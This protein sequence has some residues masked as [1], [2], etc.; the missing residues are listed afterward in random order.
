MFYPYGYSHALLPD[1]SLATYQYYK[2][3]RGKNGRGQ[4]FIAW[5]GPVRV[6]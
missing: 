4:D 2:I 3:A 1:L 6:D 5:V